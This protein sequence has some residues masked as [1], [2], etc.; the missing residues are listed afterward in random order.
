[1]G[2]ICKGDFSGFIKVDPSLSD[3]LKFDVE[4][5][6]INEASLLNLEAG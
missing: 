4:S 2:S 1:M 6:S 3:L 5:I